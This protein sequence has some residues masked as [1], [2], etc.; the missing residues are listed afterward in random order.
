MR[1]IA[2]FALFFAGPALA[3]FMEMNCANADGSLQHTFESNDDGIVTDSWKL[4][5]VELKNVALTDLGS[6]TLSS[7]VVRDEGSFTIVKES[8]RET[9]IEAELED[10][11]KV[12]LTETLL[13]KGRAGL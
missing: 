11:E 6:T 12:S 2:L 8:S 3:S 4:N 9:K 7:E 1:I 13:C 5:G 10:G